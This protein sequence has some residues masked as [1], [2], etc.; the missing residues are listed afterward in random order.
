MLWHAR[1]LFRPGL[2]RHARQIG[3]ESAQTCIDTGPDRH[4]AARRRG[5]RHAQPAGQAQFAQRSDRARC[6]KF[7][8]AIPDGVRTVVLRGAG[9]HFSA[10]L[11]LTEIRESASVAGGIGRSMVWHRAF[12][13]IQFGSVPVVAVLHGAARSRACSP[14]R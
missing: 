8:A 6:A 14:K 1:D 2:R 4:R 11:D 10:G 5:D 9:D 3:L 13:Q 7:F 12:A